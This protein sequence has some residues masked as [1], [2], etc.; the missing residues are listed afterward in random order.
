MDFPLK[1]ECPTCKAPAGEKC[2]WPR[3][4][5]VPESAIYYCDPHRSRTGL[6]MDRGLDKPGPS[7]VA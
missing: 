4:G 5:D 3:T 7:V 6:A 2:Q 1:V